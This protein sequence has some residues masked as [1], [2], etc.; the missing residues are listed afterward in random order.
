ME[1]R[2]LGMEGATDR[3]LLVLGEALR[4]A[5]APGHPP[6]LLRFAL[7]QLA[8]ALYHGGALAD[9]RAALEEA[10]GIAARDGADLALEVNQSLVLSA[11]G[12][13][14]E[15]L[16]AAEAA[17]RLDP[18]LGGLVEV[19][20]LLEVGAVPPARRRLRSLPMDPAGAAPRTLI[21]TRCLAL[22][23][24]W[25]EVEAALG[26]A[27]ATGGAAT[28]AGRGTRDL[29][30]VALECA[31]LAMEAGRWDLAGAWHAWA[32]PA[33]GPHALQDLL[34]ITVG[35][36]LALY[37]QERPG[38]TLG[39]AL[40]RAERC[41]APLALARVERLLGRLRSR[42]GAHAE[43]STRYLSAL[44]KVR[45]VW[46]GLPEEL[47]AAFLAHPERAGLRAE[48]QDFQARYG[49]FG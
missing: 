49:P 32:G 13:L 6:A 27:R 19:S 25:P 48:I 14:G 10:R 29:A 17:A 12:R 42:T 31:V 47:R 3:A 33:A 9:A 18:T 8:V 35:A 45:E 24:R 34:A 15:A 41:G 1:G 46:A 16:V 36:A 7:V 39:R 28:D 21:E 2:G 38:E 43:A 44:K 37:A 40:R 5:R 22:E 30:G 4:S 11:E 26:A 23:G 20:L